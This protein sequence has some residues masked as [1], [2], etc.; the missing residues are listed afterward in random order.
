MASESHVALLALDGQGRPGPF[1][2]LDQ[3]VVRQAAAA[4]MPG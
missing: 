1:G 2:M 4:A 3:V